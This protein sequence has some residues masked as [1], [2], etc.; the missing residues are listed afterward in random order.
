[1]AFESPGALNHVIFDHSLTL[2]KLGVR[3]IHV[4]G[5]PYRGDVPLDVHLDLHALSDEVINIKTHKTAFFR[6][7]SKHPPSLYGALFAA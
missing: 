2:L 7:A 4:N 3:V 6:G 5:L 1:M